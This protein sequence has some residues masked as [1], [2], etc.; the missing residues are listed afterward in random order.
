M[1]APGRRGK[2]PD[3]V[4][5]ATWIDERVLVRAGH[6]DALVLVGDLEPAGRADQRALA[7]R[8]PAF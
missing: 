1:D 6:V 8:Y 7:R 4:D 3:V 5:E 2:T